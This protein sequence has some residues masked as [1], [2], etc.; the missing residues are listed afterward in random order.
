MKKAKSPVAQY[1]A[2]NTAA[3]INRA[4]LWAWNAVNECDNSAKFGAPGAV[5]GALAM[6]REML[7][8]EVCPHGYAECSDGRFERGNCPDCHGKQRSDD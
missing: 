3:H 1:S 5:S 2:A 6:L 8:E 4:I 7:G